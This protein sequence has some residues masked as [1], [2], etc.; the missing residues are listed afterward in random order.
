MPESVSPLAVHPRVIEIVVD[1]RDPKRL[2]TFWSALL[3]IGVK[4]EI[5]VGCT[6][7][8]GLPSSIRQQ[9][10]Q[11]VSADASWPHTT[12]ADGNGASCRTRKAMSSV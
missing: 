5:R 10:G 7:T 2:A 12:S 8:Y 4:G 6:S 1:G 9:P 11:S 3:G